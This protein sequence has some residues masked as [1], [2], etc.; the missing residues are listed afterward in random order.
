[1]GVEVEAC[2]CDS[3]KSR[4]YKAV[5]LVS[6]NFFVEPPL[7]L[8]VQEPAARKPSADAIATAEALKRPQQQDISGGSEQ[9]I[10]C[11]FED[12]TGAGHEAQAWAGH[13]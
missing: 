6:D 1:M 8:A 9:R 5:I 10:G 4:L 11:P 12:G 3:C 2:R 7:M 13:G